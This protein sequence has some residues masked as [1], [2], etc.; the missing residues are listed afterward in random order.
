MLL[1]AAYTSAWLEL[2]LNIERGYQQRQYRA[3]QGKTIYI[4]HTL[5]LTMF[6]LRCDINE[7]SFTV[8]LI[9]E[10]SKY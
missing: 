7:G 5:L 1:R 3:D 8:N 2:V 6:K 9:D 10:I 4:L